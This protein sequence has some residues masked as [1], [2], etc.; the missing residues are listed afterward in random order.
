MVIVAFCDCGGHC[1]Q[2]CGHCNGAVSVL[3]VLS[4]LLCHCRGRTGGTAVRPVVTAVTL[5]AV[6]SSLEL[7]VVALCCGH[8]GGA[9]VVLWSYWW[10]CDHTRDRGTV[11]S[12]CE[13][14]CGAWGDAAVIL[15]SLWW[16]CGHYGGTVVLLWCHCWKYGHCHH[17]GHRGA[18][19]ILLSCQYGANVIVMYCQ[20][21]ATAGVLR[22]LW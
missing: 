1:D 8:C 19:V 14:Q 16:Y 2:Y 13:Y 22:A 7:T 12:L 9:V 21:G 20:C 5:W 6:L 10:Q 3:T 4:S 18:T 11:G 15:W 17:W